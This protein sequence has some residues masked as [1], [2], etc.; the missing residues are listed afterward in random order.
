[1]NLLVLFFSLSLFAQESPPLSDQGGDSESSMGLSSGGPSDS[2]APSISSSKKK[3]ESNIPESLIVRSSTAEAIQ[4]EELE[5]ERRNKYKRRFIRLSTAVLHD[6]ELPLELPSSVTFKGN[7]KD[8]VSAVYLKKINSLRFTPMKEGQATL[9][10]TD[11]KGRILVEYRIDV[12]KNKLDH[13]YRE[14]QTLLSDIDGIQIK[15]MNNKVIIDGFVLLPKEMGRIYNVTSQYGEQV[16][17]LVTVAPHSLKKIADLISREINNPEIEVKTINNA[18]VLQGTANSEDEKARAEILAKLYLPGTAADK[19]EQD[20]IVKK[21][22]VGNDGVINLITVRQAAQSPP[23]PPK[24]VQVVVHFVE[25]AKDYNKGFLFSFMPALKDGSQIQFKSGSEAQGSAT[26][27]TGIIDNLLPKLNWG[28]SHG[29]AR[30]LQSSS[31]IVQDTKT[32]SVNS[33]I[34]IQ[35]GVVVSAG[36]STPQFRQVGYQVRVTP[37]IFGERSDLV[38]LTLSINIASPLRSGENLTENNVETDIAVKST[39]S[40]AFAG[41]IRNV[42]GTSFN[43]R[44]PRLSNPILSIH[45][46][47]EFSR[48]QG[49]FVM[50]VTPVIKSSASQGTEKI[51]RKFR[52]SE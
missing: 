50:F 27:I 19:S 6:E 1:M 4:E 35:D 31:L 7:Y 49:Q 18:I 36:M 42:S 30:V 26:T 47:R 44:M 9:T 21:P 5:D 28:K 22:K 41:L 20:Q 52:L 34:R 14:V 11:I 46:D 17:S 32:G 45:A 37:V 48:D 13:V 12:V 10:I 29:Y 33:T 51:K 38:N 3:I 2:G 39:Q 8:V 25:L 24:M 16:L 43:K 40:A 15:I 23:P